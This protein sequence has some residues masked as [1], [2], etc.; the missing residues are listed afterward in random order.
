M[1]SANPA[2]R[3]HRPANIRA[4]LL[5]VSFFL[6][7]QLHCRCTIPHSAQSRPARREAG[8]RRRRSAPTSAHCAEALRLSRKPRCLL[9]RPVTRGRHTRHPSPLALPSVSH[10]SALWV[11]QAQQKSN[12]VRGTRLVPRC[13][14]QMTPSCVCVAGVSSDDHFT[15]RMPNLT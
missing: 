7:K 11:R 5:C 1:F 14:S 12:N 8:S 3:I 10:D 15:P 6:H 2:T 13:T 4:V 9:P